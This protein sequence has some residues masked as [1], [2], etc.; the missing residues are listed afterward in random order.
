MTNLIVDSEKTKDLEYG[1]RVQSHEC[2]YRVFNFFIKTY[3]SGFRVD[4][5][6]YEDDLVMKSYL[7]KIIGYKNIKSSTSQGIRGALWQSK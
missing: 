2:C 3:L 5:H 6:C 1:V 4:I 7:Q